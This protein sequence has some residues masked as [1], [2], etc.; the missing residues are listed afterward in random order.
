MNQQQKNNII[1]WMEA[2]RSGDYKQAF[3]RLIRYNEDGSCSYCAMGVACKSQEVTQDEYGF[4]VFM[5]IPKIGMP[6]FKWFR[7]TY[8]IE[9][10]VTPEIVYSIVEIN[11]RLKISFNEIANI[12]EKQLLCN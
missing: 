9:E 12:L 8:G 3:E 7:E 4:F 10:N 11:D 5:G 6:D 1:K 2:L